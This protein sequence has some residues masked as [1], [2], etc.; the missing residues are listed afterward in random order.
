MLYVG[1]VSPRDLIRRALCAALPSLGDFQVVFEAISPA[2]AAKCGREQHPDV[3]LVDA[4][5]MAEGLKA[6]AQILQFRP[7]AK[8]L[9]LTDVLDADM[10][11]Q[12]IRSG[13]YGCVSRWSDAAAFGK[14]LETVSQGELW[15]SHKASSQL[16]RKLLRQEG[17][18]A[19]ENGH[20]TKREWELLSLISCG[21]TN[22]QIA[23][24]LCISEHTVRTHLSTIF[25]KLRVKCRTA[26]A[27]YFFQ[28]ANSLQGQVAPPPGR[29]RNG[30]GGGGIA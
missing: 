29:S 7:D 9:L 23:E 4:L 5:P 2:D 20:F 14:T 21:H 13:C 19:D 25:G 27:L 12:A 6:A 16:A 28:H 10:E 18:K 30:I 22:K 15:I 11:W 3:L 8:I 24:L 17:Q 1:V 26:A